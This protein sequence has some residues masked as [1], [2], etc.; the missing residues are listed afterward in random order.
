MH[1]LPL[2]IENWESIKAAAAEISSR[3]QVIDVLINNAGQNIRDTVLDI[4]PDN[5]L[6]HMRAHVAGP[7][8]LVNSLL[9]L[10]ERSPRPRVINMTSGLGSISA[11]VRSRPDATYAIAKAAQNM[12]VS[13]A[14]S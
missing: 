2:D 14:H 1:I 11:G 12:L 9:P 8:L 7:A 4:D 6:D 13:R 3:T 5:L 10:L